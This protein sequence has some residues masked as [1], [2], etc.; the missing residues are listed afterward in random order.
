[1]KYGYYKFS[2]LLVP[3]RTSPWLKRLALAQPLSGI[4][5]KVS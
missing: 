1:M 2:Y 3:S 5:W 4:L